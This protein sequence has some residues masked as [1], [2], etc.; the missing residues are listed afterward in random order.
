[1][2]EKKEFEE[3]IRQTEDFLNILNKSYCHNGKEI[4]N[5]EG[6]LDEGLKSR[7]FVIGNMIGD[8]KTKHNETEIKE[9][10]TETVS[11]QN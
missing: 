3:V 10:K 4:W 6:K 7:L 2:S 11:P 8:E 9:K 5:R 1:M